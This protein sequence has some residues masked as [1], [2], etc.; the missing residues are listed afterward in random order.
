MEDNDRLI[1]TNRDPESPF[2]SRPFVPHTS[3]ND[4]AK[5]CLQSVLAD[6]DQIVQLWIANAVDDINQAIPKSREYGSAELRFLGE[7]MDGMSAV[8][9]VPGAVDES[10]K[11]ISAYEKAILFYLVGKVGRWISAAKRGEFV[12][13]DTLLDITT[14]SMMARMI[15]Q[16]GRWT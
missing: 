10:R 11:A 6:H 5:Q 16:M 9:M 15:R 14:Y 4:E 7:L 12:S 2:E 8:P 3:I 1:Y 13:D